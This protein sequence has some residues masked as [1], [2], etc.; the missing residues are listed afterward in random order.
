M[1]KQTN[2]QRVT[3]YLPEGAVAGRVE[4][5]RETGLEAFMERAVPR[6]ER[7]RFTLH[8]Q[9]GVVAGEVTCV[10]QE[11]RFCRLQYTALTERDRLRLD[12]LIE[13]E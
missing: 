3:V 1:A 4:R 9:G 2:A 7:F 13:I 10:G 8:L 5:F 12:P 6:D 11:D